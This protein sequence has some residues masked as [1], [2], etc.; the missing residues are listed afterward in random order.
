VIHRRRVPSRWCAWCGKPVTATITERVARRLT[1]QQ[2]M[3]LRERLNQRSL[4][5]VMRVG[6]PA[7][8]PNPRQGNK[9][10][11]APR[12]LG[13]VVPWGPLSAVHGQN[14]PTGHAAGA[15]AA[16]GHSTLIASWPGCWNPGEAIPRLAPDRDSQYGG[17]WCYPS[18]KRIASPNRQPLRRQGISATSP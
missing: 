17:R 4:I 8:P 1:S 15:H 6:Y 13:F 11:H 18:R 12:A 5:W 16:I 7:T 10:S 2:F 3:V 9:G 14:T